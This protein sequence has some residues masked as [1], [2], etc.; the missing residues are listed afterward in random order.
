MWT[1]LALF[2]WCS[3]RDVDAHHFNQQSQQP[4]RGHLSWNPHGHIITLAQHVQGA[5]YACLHV[6][7]YQ[8]QCSGELCSV[9]LSVITLKATALTIDILNLYMNRYVTR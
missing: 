5:Q 8:C 3:P 6:S 2:R 1:S 4:R 9:A 7:D